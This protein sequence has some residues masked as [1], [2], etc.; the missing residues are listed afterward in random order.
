[1]NDVKYVLLGR[2]KAYYEEAWWEFDT[3]EELRKTILEH[4][5]AFNLFLY[6]GVRVALEVTTNIEIG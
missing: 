4:Q 1:M 6:K 3:E 5:M 2:R